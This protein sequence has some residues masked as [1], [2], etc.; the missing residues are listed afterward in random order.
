MV[1]LCLF[2]I[3]IVSS[4]VLMLLCAS[5][6]F[7]WDEADYAGN[8]EH[9]WHFL[10]SESDYNRHGHGPMMIYLAKLGQ[11]VLPAEVPLEGQIYT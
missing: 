9:P 8:I 6:E 10:W 5:P 3:L 4:T 7:G 1:T 2:T 11:E